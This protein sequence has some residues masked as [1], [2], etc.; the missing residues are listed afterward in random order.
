MLLDQTTRDCGV[1]AAFPWKKRVTLAGA[2][3]QAL[4]R[5][6][7][8]IFI[9]R[10]DPQSCGRTQALGFG[11]AACEIQDLREI[12]GARSSLCSARDEPS[13]LWAGRELTQVSMFVLI[14]AAAAAPTAPSPCAKLSRDFTGNEVAYSISRRL[15]ERL[16]ESGHAYARA[17]GDRSQA[18]LYEDRIAKTDVEYRAKG[19][20]LITLMIGHKC[21]LPDHVTSHLTYRKRLDDCSAARGKP[22]ESKACEPILPPEVTASK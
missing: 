21:E 13:R 10:G 2:N 11:W 17:T 15:E 22:E 8:P 14:L 5:G 19:D 18:D 1:L 6:V 3:V 7:V 9:G 4:L 20:R 16:A 12:R